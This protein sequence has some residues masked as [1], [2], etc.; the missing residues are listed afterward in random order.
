MSQPHVLTPWTRVAVP[1]ADILGSD[2][3]L[4]TYAANL[5]DVDAGVEKC[6]VVYRDP[7]AFFR[8]TF[9]T[10]ALDELLRDVSAVLAGGA[11]NRVLQ[12]R[13][14]FGGGKTHTLI[15]LLHIARSRA[16]LSAA[17]Q[18]GAWSD[19]G[20]TRVA[21]LPCMDLS[22][23]SGRQV[24]RP[25]G[26]GA[27]EW[28]EKQGIKLQ[29]LWGELA[30]RIGGPAAY[31]AVAED[32]RRRSKPGTGALK[33]ILDGPPTLILLDEVLSYVEA[34][35]AV[36]AGDSNLGRQTMLFLQD[37]TDLV[38]GLPHCAVVY[39]LQQSVRQAVGDEGLLEMLD[40][41]VSR[42]DAKKEPV[43]GDEVLRVVQRRL[44]QDLG[45]PAVRERVASEY[46][47]LLEGFLTA[48]GQSEAEKRAARERAQVFAGRILDAYPF[49]PEL[50]DLMYHRWGSLPSYQRTR[51]A[52]QFLATVI[53]ALWKQGDAAGP[54]IGPGD[55]ALDDSM[56]RNTFFSQVGEREA[57]KSVLDSDLLGATARC[58][59]V[60]DSVAGDAPALA[61]FKPGTRLTRALAL[62]SFGAKP[63]EDRGVV[64]SDLLLACQVP[65]LPADILDV[66]LQGLSETLLYIHG[67]GRRFRFEKRPNL[68][69]LIDDAI[70]TVPPHEARDAIRADLETRIGGRAGFALW[71]TDSG[72][73][74]DRRPRFQLAFLGPEY[75]LKPEDDLLRLCR[76]WTDNCGG[77]K[78][79]YRNAL[80]FALPAALQADRARDAARRLLAIDG[81]LT[82][83]R[84]HGFEPDDVD[85]LERR[86]RRAADDLQAACR[87]LYPV[88]LLPVSAPRDT[89][90]PIRME[91]FDI[92]TFQAFGAG[93]LDGIH[94]V[95]EN[96]IF[97][98]AVPAKLVAC[99]HLGEGEPG[100]RS[101]WI[102]GPELAD[103]FFGSV[104]YPKLLTLE[105]LKETVS[106]GVSRGSY[107][108]VMGGREVDG[109]LVAPGKDALT[110][111]EE[112]NRDDIDLSAGSFI[113]SRP[114][115]EA[116]LKAQVVTPPPLPP[117][118][119]V[120]VD[121]PVLPPVLPPVVPPPP[122]TADPKR[123]VLEF[124]AKGGQLFQAFGPLVVLSEWAQ[125]GFTAHVTIVAQGDSPI[126][127]NLYETAVLMSLDEEGI[128]VL[129]K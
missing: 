49:H 119:P 14:P 43:S 24:P 114:W 122:V 80:A 59:R 11:G 36:P 92:Q 81:L 126:D 16:V 99:T 26:G 44:F 121:P 60:D 89:S 97:T 72:Q 38:R 76:D 58:R 62:Y 19:P 15:A 10:H 25:S 3:D 9:L 50:L 30:W 88:I 71:P 8:A 67:A 31:E 75:A 13:T 107:G 41:L 117:K 91:R 6:P 104:Q 12:L 54:L 66:A 45:D 74:P 78:R 42:V 55:V 86:K 64:R 118:P 21:V 100:T 53:G 29:T 83:R 34:A 113:V 98:S 96:W 32:D 57:M 112:T 102:A 87:Q 18:L 94:K 5:G 108:Y 40:G 124:R 1:H 63:G 51:G 73:V 120:I 128:E 95:L 35:L 56:V 7:V 90:D 79:L 77:G 103:Q 129:R 127:R 37:L 70:R 115:A 28:G 39:S 61:L 65:G 84:R 111:S 123:V 2:F 85:D 110:F 101:H 33:R 22:A 116:W 4:S 69:K 52:L 109:K 23:A 46:A 47:A 125:N 17:G 106:K 20:P 93:I 27:E 48:E 68:N 82:D 105:G